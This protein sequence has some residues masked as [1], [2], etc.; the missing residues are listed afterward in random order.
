MN[1]HVNKWSESKVS[2]LARPMVDSGRISGF[3]SGAGAA[4][5]WRRRRRVHRADSYKFGYL[6]FDHAKTTERIWICESNL[7][8]KLV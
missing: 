3:V 2:K 4:G 8:S 7:Y 6:L 1:D 5:A